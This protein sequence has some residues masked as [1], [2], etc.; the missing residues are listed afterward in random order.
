MRVDEQFTVTF[1]NLSG[2]TFAGGSA[3]TVTVTIVDDDQASFS[4]GDG[5]VTEGDTGSVNMDFVVSLSPASSR[6]TS[7]DLDRFYQ[8]WK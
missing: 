7:V 6:T 2:A 4:I 3:P 1:E 8:V 5:S